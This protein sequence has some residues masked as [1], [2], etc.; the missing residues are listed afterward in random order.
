MASP[1]E[2]SPL[3]DGAPLHMFKPETLRHELG[4]IAERVGTTRYPNPMPT[5]AEWDTIICEILPASPRGIGTASWL[6]RWDERQRAALGLQ[7]K[8]LETHLR[9][10]PD[11]DWQGLP[12]PE[13]ILAPVQWRDRMLAIL[14]TG[15]IPAA[16]V[17]LT[18]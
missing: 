1:K 11:H 13:W 5:D 7:A 15:T 6:R 8:T 12:N 3:F 16:W 4:T 9:A 14:G 18:E 2:R 10:F 17:R